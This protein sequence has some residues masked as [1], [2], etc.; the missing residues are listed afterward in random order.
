M[1]HAR[2]RTYV[3]ARSSRVEALIAYWR[4]RIVVKESRSFPRRCVY[5]MFGPASSRFGWRDDN[6]DFGFRRSGIRDVICRR[7]PR[8]SSTCSTASQATIIRA[9]SFDCGIWSI[10]QPHPWLSLGVKNTSEFVLIISLFTNLIEG[11]TRLTAKAPWRN[12]AGDPKMGPGP[13]LTHRRTAPG[14]IG[15]PEKEADQY[16]C[17]Q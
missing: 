7:R 4:S 9:R 12:A 5:P 13:S 8:L 16:N 15:G 6:L 14:S 3:H 1:A 10:V 11:A 2:S 17:R